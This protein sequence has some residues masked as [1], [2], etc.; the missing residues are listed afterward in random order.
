MEQ[1]GTEFLQ[2]SFLNLGLQTAGTFQTPRTIDMPGLSLNP[3]IQCLDSHISAQTYL[4]VFKLASPYGIM[5]A[6]KNIILITG[7][8][9][10]HRAKAVTSKQARTDRCLQPTAAL[11]SNKPRNCWQSRPTTSS[12]E[13][14]RLRKATPLLR[15]SNLESD[16]VLLSYCKSTSQAKSQSQL[17]RRKSRVSMAGMHQ[18]SCDLVAP[19][20][21]L[22]PGRH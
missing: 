6:T 16:W 17:R 10:P 1:F 22:P 20:T 4:L 14:A 18:L 13:A 3:L 21:R 15:I 11:A 19:S 2:A 12:L 7:G 8:E 5:A 9:S